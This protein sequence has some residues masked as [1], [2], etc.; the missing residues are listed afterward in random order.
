MYPHL[1]SDI[2]PIN[3][4]TRAFLKLVSLEKKRVSRHPNIRD[5]KSH[6]SAK[7]E[8]EREGEREDGKRNIFIF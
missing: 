5:I 3:A 6:I 2:H 8:K 1:L 7:E 4:E